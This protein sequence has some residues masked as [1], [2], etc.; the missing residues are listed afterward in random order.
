MRNAA[1]NKTV[2]EHYVA[3]GMNGVAM[4]VLKNPSA[5]VLFKDLFSEKALYYLNWLYQIERVSVFEI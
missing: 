4:N 3:I 1:F 5:R 2:V